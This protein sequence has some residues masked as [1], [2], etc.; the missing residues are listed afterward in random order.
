[1]RRVVDELTYFLASTGSSLWAAALWPLLVWA[2]PFFYVALP[3]PLPS[4]LL[5]IAFACP[6]SESERMARH[7]AARAPTG[8][9]V[10]Q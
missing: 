7:S 2:A 5:P 10:S 3:F 1:M 8:L 4:R 6:Q 9:L